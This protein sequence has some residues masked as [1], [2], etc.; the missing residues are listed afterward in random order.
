MLP[1]FSQSFFNAARRILAPG[2][3]HSLRADG[4]VD[5]TARPASIQRI[6][7]IIR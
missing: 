4:E 3:A 5:F 2:R 6:A 7:I 1:T